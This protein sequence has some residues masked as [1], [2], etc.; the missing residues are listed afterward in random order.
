MASDLSPIQGELQAQIMP[1]LWRVGEATVEEV[2]SALPRRYRSAYNTVQ[3][4]LNRLTDRGLLQ[5]DR[6]GKTFVYRP[7]ISEAEYFSRSIEQSLASTSQATRNSVLA[8]LIGSLDA[9]GRREVQALAKRIARRR[10]L[11]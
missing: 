8:Q 7:R 9:D 4:I 11:A 1:V 2:R 5:R 6:R 10:D 3:T